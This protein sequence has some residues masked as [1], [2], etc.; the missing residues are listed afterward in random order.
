MKPYEARE[1]THA[2]LVEKLDEAQ[3]DLF[4]LRFQLAVSQS[5]NTAR[6][7]ELRRDIARMRT[8]LNEWERD[9]RPLGYEAGAYEREGPPVDEPVAVPDFPED[10][11]RAVAEAEEETGEVP[12]EAAAVVAS[13]EREGQPDDSPA[14]PEPEPEEPK[15]GRRWGL[16][17]R[18]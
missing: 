12:E 4:N 18:K 2:E 3:D 7:G 1:M 6:L 11:E 16:R 10:E 9:G 13:D 15:R 17:S 5:D 8:V 14:E